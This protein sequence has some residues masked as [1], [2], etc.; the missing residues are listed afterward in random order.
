AAG[1]V[2]LALVVQSAVGAPARPRLMP[3]GRPAAPAPVSPPADES[4]PPLPAVRPIVTAAPEAERTSPRPQVV[5]LLAT[6]P[7]GVRFSVRVPEPAFDTIAAIGGR[8]QA[9]EVRLDLAGFATEAHMGEPGM[10]V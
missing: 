3:G 7:G 6:S 4:A 9:S 2:S 1:L 5:R 10:P 8:G